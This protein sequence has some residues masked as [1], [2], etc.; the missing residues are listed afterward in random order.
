MNMTELE[1]KGSSLENKSNSLDEVQPYLDEK[2]TFEKVIKILNVEL[3]NDV[4]GLKRVPDLYKKYNDAKNSLES[5]FIVVSSEAPNKI[6][7]ALNEATSVIQNIN[8]LSDAKVKLQNDVHKHLLINQPSIDE[9]K[10]LQLKIKEYEKYVNYLQ[11]ILTVDDLSSSIQAALVIRAEDK[12]V[13]DYQSL[14]LLSQQV[15]SSKCTHL[16]YY[17]N[18]TVKYW[19]DLLKKKFGSEFEEILSTLKW[20]IVTTSQLNMTPNINPQ[21][22]Q[23][24][25]VRIEVV[26]KYLLQLQ[27]PD[28]VTT[29]EESSKVRTLIPEF[30]SLSLPL[31]LLLKQLHKRFI[32]H[33]MG[34]KETNNLEKPEWY[35]TQVLSWIRDNSIFLDQVIQP[36]LRKNNIHV[37]AKVEF[38]QGLV[39]IVSEKLLKDIPILLDDDHL[40]SHTIDETLLFDKELQSL[41]YSGNNNQ[42]GCLTVLT[43]EDV[44]FKRWLS[45]EKKYAVAKIDNMLSTAT[46]WKSVYVVQGELDELKVPECGEQFMTLIHTITGRYKCVPQPYHKLQ[47]LNLQLELL[48]DFRLR[49]VQLM[50]SEE[51]F[52]SNFCPILNAINYVTTVLKEWCDLPFFLQMQCYKVQ[53][54]RLQKSLGIFELAEDITEEQRKIF[55]AQLAKLNKIDFILE[56][57]PI[58]SLSEGTVFDDFTDLLKHVQS[59]MIT[60]LVDFVFMEVKAK[61]RQYRKDKWFSMDLTTN[62]INRTVSN[63]LCPILIV[64]QLNLQKLKN[65]LALTLFNLCWQKLTALINHFIFEEVVNLNIFNNGGAAQ[66]N[67]DMTRNLFPLFTEYT[68]R[69][70]NYFKE[71]KESC[72]L[73]TLANGSALLLYELLTNPVNTDKNQALMEIGV[74]KLKP[75]QASNILSKRSEISR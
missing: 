12:A 3:G 73:L 65:G 9:L 36:I 44:C 46:A 41:G 21:L 61:S 18:E 58:E 75:E 62:V 45:M 72:I 63:S 37:S 4:S 31:Q 7:R 32:Y 11:W 27:L 19:F 71:V 49:L 69:P 6:T 39:Q 33:F 59:E 2:N 35:F 68:Q 67:Y 20:P 50:K 24:A 53:H 47:F 30:K 1:G 29:E 57:L 15:Q 5:E 43:S 40:L 55:K 14:S 66:F 48:D 17:I 8:T 60:K 25:L 52:E 42:P 10:Q 28:Y 56:N 26:L 74:N 54:Q 70:D 64:L 34:R 13:S 23:E 51:P 16:V 38:I 22:K